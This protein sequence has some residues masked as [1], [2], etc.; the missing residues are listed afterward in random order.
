MLVWSEILLRLGAGF[1]WLA[2]VSNIYQLGR[3][4]IQLRRMGVFSSRCGWILLT[5]SLMTRGIALGHLTFHTLFDTILLFSWIT[6]TI[7]IYFEWRHGWPVLGAVVLGILA[8]TSFVLLLLPRDIQPLLPI[9]QSRVLVLHIA[10]NF[11]AYGAFALSF[12]LGLMYLGQELQL[13]KKR[14]TALYYLLPGLETLENLTDILARIGFTLLTLGIALGSIYA[15]FA[16]SSFWDWN[17]KE[18]WT[19]LIWTIYAV[20]IYLRHVKAWRG[21]RSVIWVLIGFAAVL[22][23]YFGISLKLATEHRFLR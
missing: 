21:K 11:T 1:L 5:L 10:L 15:K 18:T 12:I 3:K 22:I 8:A 20:F 23:N 6:L 13:K 7:Y 16:W 2:F 17:V 9:L 19:L 14:I 4:S